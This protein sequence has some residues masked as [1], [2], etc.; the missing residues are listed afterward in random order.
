MATTLE[1]AKSPADTSKLRAQLSEVGERFAGFDKAL[2]EGKQRKN[3]DDEKE[4]LLQ[5]LTRVEDALH[6]EITRRVEASKTLQH[7][8][9]DVGNTL[10]K[11]LQMKVAYRVELLSAS[12]EAL[13]Q[14][15]ESLEK[16]F[17][18]SEIMPDRLRVET[19]ALAYDI[20]RIK[21]AF[22]NDKQRPRDAAD[23]Q[24]TLS[25]DRIDGYFRALEE[26]D[27]FSA[28]HAMVHTLKAP[29]TH[30][31]LN[32]KFM[33]Y[34]LEEVQML[35]EELGHANTEREKNDDHI[36]AAINQYTIVMQTKLRNSMDA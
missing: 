26:A 27:H 35:K 30:E 3:C 31:T 19:E 12:I 24:V 33:S 2:L 9:M 4:E 17:A 34:I 22:E 28:L 6:V 5:I 18:Q 11:K 16:A 36:F 7:M 32:D 8:A 20:Q 1:F 23:K 25:A 29:S 14:R 13:N 21:T 15:A 10:T